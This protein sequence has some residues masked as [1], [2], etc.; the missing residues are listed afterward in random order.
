MPDQRW[1]D[2]HV[3]I[4]VNKPVSAHMFDAYLKEI[5]KLP[6]L[7]PEKRIFLDSKNASNF[8]S[9]RAV[10]V[11]NNS[12]RVIVSSIDS[13]PS[14]TASTARSTPA[15]Q[16][17]SYKRHFSATPSVLQYRRQRLMAFSTFYKYSLLPSRDLLFPRLSASYSLHLQDREGLCVFGRTLLPPS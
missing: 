15:L 6:G 4:I 3:Y 11:L 9:R 1:A 7:L 10:L 17:S 14:L 5:V 16:I 8:R 12:L 13:L 2:Y